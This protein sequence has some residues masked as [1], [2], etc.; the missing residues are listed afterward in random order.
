MEMCDYVKSIIGKTDTF[1]DLK[2][3]RTSRT[4]TIQLPIGI[5]FGKRI[6]KMSTVAPTP[7]TTTQ[8]RENLIPKLK[9]MI[10]MVNP[11]LDFQKN[12]SKMNTDVQNRNNRI[13]ATVN[14]LFCLDKG[15]KEKKYIQFNGTTG[16]W[17]PSNFK[18][19]LMKHMSTS[20]THNSSNN[21]TVPL[22]NDSNK[23]TNKSS[24]ASIVASKVNRNP[25]SKNDVSKAKATKRSLIVAPKFNVSLIAHQRIQAEISVHRLQS[26]PQTAQV[27]TL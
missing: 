5:F 20:S 3:E 11:K 21:C 25:S 18:K 15:E 19:H 26:L 1:A 12:E 10:L 9:K 16:Y 2:T 8:L 14:C 4:N 13:L 6:T 27:Y 17:N 23:S 7:L 22:A 24:N